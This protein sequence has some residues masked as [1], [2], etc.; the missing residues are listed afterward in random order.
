M[1]CLTGGLCNPSPPS[2]IFDSGPYDILTGPCIPSCATSRS[3][4]SSDPVSTFGSDEWSSPPTRSD[5]IARSWA[6]AP[7]CTPNIAQRLE[8]RRAFQGLGSSSKYA[9]E[10]SPAYSRIK[11]FQVVYEQPTGDRRGWVS[12]VEIIM[13]APSEARVTVN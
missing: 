5:L 8:D 10:I 1:I 11:N 12:S 4:P 13:I 3:V 9:T 7:C 6:C 2:S